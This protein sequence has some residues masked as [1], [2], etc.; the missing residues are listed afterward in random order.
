MEKIKIQQLQ[1]KNQQLLTAGP[2][3]QAAMAAAAAVPV[4]PVRP[5]VAAAAGEKKIDKEVVGDD[6]DDNNGQLSHMKYLTTVQVGANMS[7]WKWLFPVYRLINHIMK[8]PT[9]PLFICYSISAHH[10]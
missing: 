1:K 6:D 9:R 5:V 10:W 7:C 8:H 2:K 3:A 4:Q